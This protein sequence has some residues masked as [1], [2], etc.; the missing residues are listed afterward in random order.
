MTRRALLL[1][2]IPLLAPTLFAAVS[3]GPDRP[4]ASAPRASYGGGDRPGAIVP[5]GD[6]WVGF[7]FQAPS[8]GQPTQIIA[9]PIAANGTPIAGEERIV[10][11]ATGSDLLA[12]TTPQGF[13]LVWSTWNAAL[14]RVVSMA[15]PVGQDF[16]PAGTPVELPMPM[17]SLAC[18]GSRC[19]AAS[20][21]IASPLIVLDLTGHVTAGPLDPGL[22]RTTAIA[23]TAD[24][25]A[26]AWH[27]QGSEDVRVAFMSNDGT[28]TAPTTV[29]PQTSAAVEV[30]VAAHPLGALVAWGQDNFVETAIVR[31][32]GTMAGTATL[33]AAGRL[34]QE[35]A[36]A[37]NGSEYLV[38]YCSIT[39][40]GAYIDGFSEK[41][42]FYSRMSP[43]ADVLD[44][45]ARPLCSLTMSN[46]APSVV[47]NGSAFGATWLHYGQR[48]ASSSFTA[49]RVARIEAG[50]GLSA[51]DGVMLSPRPSFQ[52]GASLA[53][54]AESALV[55][56]REINQ[57]GGFAVRAMRVNRNVDALDASPLVLSDSSE[58]FTFPFDP[59]PLLPTRGRDTVRSATDG[60]DFIA[61]WRDTASP[62]PS[63]T[64][65]AAFV[66]G[67]S[68][69][70]RKL[71]LGFT[72]RPAG[73]G[74]DGSGYMLGLNNADY[75]STAKLVRLASD[76]QVLWSN[77]LPASI[78][79]M[80]TIPGRTLVVTFDTMDIYDTDGRAVARVPVASGVLAAVASNGREFL[81]LTATFMQ[82]AAFL[83]ATR[84]APDG[85]TPH[86][87]KTPVAQTSTHL[88]QAAPLGSRW[89]IAW[90]DATAH[91]VTFPDLTP[92]TSEDAAS[93]ANMAPDG[94]GGI[95]LMA[96]RTVPVDRWMTSVIV[97]RQVIDD[98]SAPPAGRRRSVGH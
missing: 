54:G 18:N 50:G 68:G 89:L 70:V 4:V 27:R 59:A 51:T 75:P 36:V 34:V 10:H 82:N 32:D 92:V 44:A 52:W 28:M 94:S 87:V 42:L 2:A 79:A 39:G 7:T 26:L 16:K 67:H 24:G 19:A 37:G 63:S 65:E 76:G 11:E 46:Y 12:A 60:R 90:Q 55:T 8:Y 40:S 98:S 29:A 88:V 84:I 74:W 20:F 31:R 21:F 41:H 91:M 83:V 97:T 43:A 62:N 14:L 61:I 80:A 48:L 72:G 3:F 45:A 38:A 77:P 23:A 15:M 86:G 78:V 56:W 1:L 22:A 13:L 33:P 66:D 58:A 25:F 57:I 64:F 93:I 95:L 49:M 71:D 5:F 81:V 47:A 69:S 17:R 30:A 96:Q 9:T 73:L 35:V 6:G 53:V 85:S